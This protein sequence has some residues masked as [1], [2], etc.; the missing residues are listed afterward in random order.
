VAGP[1]SR[2]VVISIRA[3]QSL[4]WAAMSV[5]SASESDVRAVRMAV[6][7]APAARMACTAVA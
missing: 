7:E 3:L 5:M 1:A 2:A 4:S 6:A